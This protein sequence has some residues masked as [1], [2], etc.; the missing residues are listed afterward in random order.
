LHTLLFLIISHEQGCLI[1]A[2]AMRALALTVSILFLS[3]SFE[4]NAQ[5]SWQPNFNL[6]PSILQAQV[7]NPCPNGDCGG[8]DAPR[9]SSTVKRSNLT[10]PSRAN[11]V[12]V[13]K[14]N[15]TPSAEARKR[16][17]ATFVSKTRANDPAS[18]DQLAEMFAS[19]DVIGLVGKAMTGMGLRPDN[20]ADAYAVYW[21]SA[22][23]ASV[24]S[25]ATPSRAQFGKMKSQAAAALASTPEIVTAT[26][27][28]KQEFAESLLIQ[29]ALIDSSLEQAQNDPAMLKAIGKAVRQGARAMG[30]DLKSMTLTEDGFVPSTSETGSI[31]QD[32]EAVQLASTAENQNASNEPNYMLI[33]AAG[34]AG[35]GGMFLLGKAMGRKN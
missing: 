17:L 31:Q 12:A 35:L 20:L 18:A 23:H 30:I 22:W 25:N 29:A 4:A 32:D 24:G 26:N 15:Y 27:A 11:P 28:A 2:F 9:A 1:G 7:L 19:T 16:N 8:G 6:A 33:A 14:L 5:I 13:A 34:G 3:S 21:S 10:N